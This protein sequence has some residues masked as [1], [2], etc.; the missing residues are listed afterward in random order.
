MPINPPNPT[1]TWRPSPTLTLD[2]VIAVNVLVL[3]APIETP[4][5][6]APAL[7]KVLP[8]VDVSN[9]TRPLMTPVALLT[10]LTWEP[11]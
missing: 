8:A 4:P 2:P 5:V 3:F 10:I 9:A 11:P 1:L 7:V 6:M